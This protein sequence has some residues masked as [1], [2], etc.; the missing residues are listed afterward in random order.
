MLGTVYGGTGA[1]ARPRGTAPVLQLILGWT[2][3]KADSRELTAQ[4]DP[5]CVNVYPGS[6]APSG[7]LVTLMRTVGAS[8][9]VI[10][11]GRS[12]ANCENT[13]L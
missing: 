10:P 12:M 2:L 4:N 13:S 3:P 11:A 7:L 1:L 8:G 9:A 6:V 5:S